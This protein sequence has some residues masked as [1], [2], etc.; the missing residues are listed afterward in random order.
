MARVTAELLALQMDELCHAIERYPDTHPLEGHY[1][2]LDRNIRLKHLRHHSPPDLA[3]VLDYNVLMEGLGTGRLHFLVS[4]RHDEALQRLGVFDQHLLIV[5]LHRDRAT[6]EQAEVLAARQPALLGDFETRYCFDDGGRF[7]K[8]SI[9]PR[10]IPDSRPAFG[11]LRPELKVVES[12]MTPS[13]FWLAGQ[14]L[15]ALKQTV[16]AYPPHA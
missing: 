10:E 1:L 6:Q 2:E 13:D 15:H 9:F 7:G 3:L 12:E 16:G 8:L 14:A 4:A 11:Q 5:G